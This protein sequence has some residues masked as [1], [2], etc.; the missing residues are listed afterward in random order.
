MFVE[1]VAAV[2]MAPVAQIS[3]DAEHTMIIRTDGSLWTTSK[4]NSGELGHGTRINSHVPLQIM[5]N[6]V[7]TLSTSGASTI[8]IKTDGSL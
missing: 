7:Q 5:S 8:L 1:I 3:A 2:F 6:A 4:K